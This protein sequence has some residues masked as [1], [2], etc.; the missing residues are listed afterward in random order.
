MTQKRLL[1]TN[2]RNPRLVAST[3]LRSSIVDR[4]G[5]PVGV[6]R[7]RFRHRDRRGPVLGSGRGF[8]VCEA[9]SR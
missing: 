8:H 5:L 9:G 2:S 6:R 4:A 3:P 1:L 7:R